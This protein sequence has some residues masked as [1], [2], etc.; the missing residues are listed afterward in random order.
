M[1]VNTATPISQYHK[2]GVDRL[3]IVNYHKIY[4]KEIM[5]SVLHTIICGVERPKSPW[6]N[7]Y[8]N[9]RACKKR[10]KFE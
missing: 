4:D 9:Y 1:K 3:R 2:K 10:C 8:I 5:L 6:E 7:K